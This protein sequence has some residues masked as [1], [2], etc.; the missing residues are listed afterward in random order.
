MS[1]PKKKKLTFYQR[2][3][4]QAR[5]F[6][7]LGFYVIPIQAGKKTPRIKGWTDLRL[8]THEQLKSTF[9][10]TDNIGVLLGEPSGGLVDVDLDCDEAIDLAESFLPET[11]RIHGREGKRE[12]H[13]TYIVNP[14]PDPK[15]Y[16][17]NDGTTLLELRS[18]GQ[19]T[20]IPPSIHPSGEPIFWETAGEPGQPKTEELMR[21]LRRLAAC[22]LLAR[23]WSPKGSRHDLTLPLAGALLK[24]GWSVN[25]VKH[26][27]TAAAR[28]ANDEEWES[29]K[30]DVKSTA[31]RLAAGKPATG[32][33]TLIEILG[34]K[35]VSKLT[36][37]LELSPPLPPKLLSIAQ[38]WPEPAD[39]AA[40]RGLAVEFVSLVE[41]HSEADPIALLSQF[42]VG[43]GNIIG[44]SAHFQVEG[45]KH[46]TN[47]FVALVGPTSKARKGSALSQV[48]R[49]LKMVDPNW[50]G[51]CELSGLSSGEGL[52]W[53]VR[54]QIFSK[55]GEKVLDVG[56]EDK[57]LFVIEPEIAQQ[58]K[59]MTT[60]SNIL[61]TILRQA[62][63]SGDLRTATKNAPGQATGAH[64]SLI[65]HITQQELLRC[66]TETET[67]NGFANR[68]IWLAVRRSKPLPEGGNLDDDAFTKLV[69]KLKATVKWA[70][71]IKRMHRS[72]KAKE[73]WANVYPKLS[74][75][76]AGLLGAVISRA[77]AQVVRLSVIYALLDK[78]STI[79]T[80]HLR[81]ALALWDYAERSATF[82]FGDS[83]G[84]PVADEIL[85]ALQV[86]TQGLTRTEISKLF[87]G[88]QKSAE[89]SR[90][91]V[92]LAQSGLVSYKPEQTGGRPDQRWFVLTEIAKNAKKG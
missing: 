30:H 54:D 57:R 9:R 85:R 13:R 25:D 65:G 11:E 68:F 15:K 4:K 88:H 59:L 5:I 63:D 67:A 72:K 26:F 2:V 22:T 75:G 24:S 48:K 35:V 42:L 3:L 36:E 45:D 29:R 86:N 56:V 20:L 89:I 6:L 80:Q 40:F 44:R 47:L 60:A 8:D 74:E 73:L 41:P 23:R 33:P 39:E 61:S 51:A 43:F 83:L 18:T 34:D 27:I 49:L 1:Q 16:T 70:R 21:S 91:L 37:W 92:V 71:T 14:I 55:D 64:V 66:L 50:A 82:I 12:S 10:P 62:W 19:Q 79:Q 17:D 7:A 58:L 32:I 31:E 81:A 76:K 69:K 90:A 77:E 28:T 84:D 46:F 53:A 38:S 87:A 78:S 52:V